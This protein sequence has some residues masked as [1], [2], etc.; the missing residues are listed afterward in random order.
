MRTVMICILC[1]ITVEPLKLARETVP[2]AKIF[3]AAQSALR[4][5]H[6]IMRRLFLKNTVHETRR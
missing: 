4:G 1:V 6:F 5:D 3:I 2:P